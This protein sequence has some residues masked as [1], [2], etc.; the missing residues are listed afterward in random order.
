MLS[1][2]MLQ[3]SCSSRKTATRLETEH[4]VGDISRVLVHGPT[5]LLADTNKCKGSTL[6][7]VSEKLRLANCSR[8]KQGLVQMPPLERG[9]AAG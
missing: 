7:C 4:N 1:P 5:Y 8:L 2:L 3:A 6:R 9:L